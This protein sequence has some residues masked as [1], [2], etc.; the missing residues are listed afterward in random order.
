MILDDDMEV[1]I[2]E[3]VPSTTLDSGTVCIPESLYLLRWLLRKQLI[4]EENCCRILLELL[5]LERP[6][7]LSK[8]IEAEEPEIADVVD[9]VISLFAV[10]RWSLDTKS[11]YKA[12]K[13]CLE[14][15]TS[16]S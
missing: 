9:V 15:N 11:L 6:L 16:F 12:L 4:L 7:A 2:L 14:P 3:R 10:G 1:F 8:S 5:F 13:W